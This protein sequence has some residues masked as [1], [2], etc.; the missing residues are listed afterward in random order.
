M[1]YIKLQPGQEDFQEPE[2]APEKLELAKDDAVIRKE[3]LKIKMIFLVLGVLSLLPWNILV[4]A[5]GFFRKKLANTMFEDNFSLYLQAF[6]VFSNMLGSFLMFFLSKKFT[7]R[8][9]VVAAATTFSLPLMV[10][11]ALAKINTD[12]WAKE[13][14]MAVLILHSINGASHG[15]MTSAHSML[16]TMIDATILKTY[17][18]GKG[19]AGLV[20]SAIALSTLAFPSLDVVSAAFYYFLVMTLLSFIVGIGLTLYLLNLDLV[21]E[22]TIAANYKK[23][24]TQNEAAMSLGEITRELKPQCISA[25]LSTISSLVVFPATMTNLKS[26]NPTTGTAWSDKFFLPVTVFL[27]WAVGDNSGKILTEFC[28]WPTRDTIVWFS[29]ARL[30]LVPLVIM[31]NIQPRTIPVWFKSDAIPSILCFLTAFTNGYL[32]N[33]NLAYA[34][35]YVEGKENKGRA[36]MVMFFFLAGGLAVGSG[37]IFL[38]PVILNP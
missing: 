20:G 11:T 12:S 36:S 25:L 14:F 33:L 38:I 31:T 18:V 17:Y 9:L 30:I 8:V 15:L 23:E 21:K 35:G 22:R 7:P 32:V 28:S 19:L 16:S 2:P 5:E 13:F 4:N 3:I 37:T 34:P 27:V 10:I 1:F 29:V 6:A 24:E 26:M